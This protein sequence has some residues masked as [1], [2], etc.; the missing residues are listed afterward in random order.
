MKKKMMKR[1]LALGALMVFVITGSAMAADYDKIVVKNGE[2]KTIT[3]ND[4]N[5]D[6]TGFQAVV[7]QGVDSSLNV[8]SD[9]INITTKAVG[10]GDSDAVF[11]NEGGKIVLGDDTTSNIVINN[12]YTHNTK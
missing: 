11:A 9:T 12:T 7:V 8:K 5:V 4:V 3:E 2:N 1:S 10:T 6:Y